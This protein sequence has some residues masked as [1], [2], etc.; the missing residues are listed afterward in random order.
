ML[1][2]SNATVALIGVVTRSKLNSCSADVG[3]SDLS[4]QQYLLHV[5]ALYRTKLQQQQQKQQ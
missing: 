2:L 3:T 5:I 1:L 4:L